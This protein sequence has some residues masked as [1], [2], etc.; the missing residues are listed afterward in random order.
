MNIVLLAVTQG[1]V[2]AALGA[3]VRLQYSLFRGFDLI[4]APIAV[5][6]AEMFLL[7]AKLFPQATLPALVVCTFVAIGAGVV[8]AV[9]WN[10]I[11]DRLWHGRNVLGSGIFILSLGFTTLV[12]GAVGLG[13][14]PG[15]RVVP[16]E[17]PSLTFGNTNVGI[18]TAYG[19]VWGLMICIGT[20]VWSRSRLGFAFDL[21]A[22]NQAFATEIGISRR[23]L[24]IGSGISTGALAGVAGAYTA[25]ANGS[26][27][28]GGLILFLYGAGAAL[29]LP[30][31]LLICSLQ[32]G[33]FLG[34][35]LV[36]TQLVAS[37]AFATVVLF[38][39]VTAIL[40]IRGTS[41][42]SQGLR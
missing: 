32:G 3:A 10:A 23:M 33:F 35:L 7:A 40:L 1:L 37:P 26:T 29:L 31:P 34:I 25:L 15:L 36:V 27:P 38:G 5:L 2:F 18:P 21:W 28:E 4:I 19:I 14:G 8:L 30:K 41:R 17:M 13:R 12:T 24:L 39:A 11:V 6:A 9:L 16:W 20:T 42:V 22:Q